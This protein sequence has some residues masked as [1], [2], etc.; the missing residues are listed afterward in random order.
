MKEYHIRLPRSE[1]E[2]N[3]AITF[4]S[5]NMFAR[6]GAC[7]PPDKTPEHLFIAFHNAEIVG[8]LCIEFG[9]ED[10]ELPIEFFFDLSSIPS[11]ISYKRSKTIYYSRWNSVHKKLGPVIWLAVSEY[12]FSCGMEFAAATAKEEMVEHCHETL[13][14]WWK[15]IPKALVRKENIGKEEELYFLAQ[16]PPMPCLGILKEHLY[17]LREIVGRICIEHSIVWILE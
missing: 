15:T 13:G 9:N 8:T 12:A 6:H 17:G 2:R 10:M 16:D 14:F 7:P 11:P 5:S 3:Q 1:N 4:I